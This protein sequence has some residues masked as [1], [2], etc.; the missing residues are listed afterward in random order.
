MQFGGWMYLWYGI[1]CVSSILENFAGVPFTKTWT[2]RVWRAPKVTVDP[3]SPWVIL[4]PTNTTAAE[5]EEYPRQGQMQQ[6][7]P[8]K[9]VMSDQ[10]LA[11]DSAS[12]N[13]SQG[14]LQG[15]RP[16]IQELH[17]K[18][19]FSDPADIL[20]N[21]EK[22]Y[23]TFANVYMDPSLPWSSANDAFYVLISVKGV[24]TLH[25]MLR[26]FSKLISIGVFAVGTGLFASS[27]LITIVVAMVAATL[28]LCAGIFGRVTAMYMASEMMRNK[29]VLHKVVKNRTEAGKYMEALFQQPEIAC[30]VL[31]HIVTQGRCIKK[32]GRRTRW[33]QFLGVLARPYDLRRIATNGTSYGGKASGVPPQR[34]SQTYSSSF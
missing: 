31:G 23:N 18:S 19:S 2:I 15:R 6:N 29:P 22:G 10:I 13:Q 21:L 24:S 26:V 33:S 3:D 27:T 11:Q 1:V 32:F 25:A 12:S 9:P 14:L 20:T 5:E 7:I 8:R 16:T 4:P 28:I 34:Q 17:A 30:E